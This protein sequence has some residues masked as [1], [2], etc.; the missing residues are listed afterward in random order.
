MCLWSTSLTATRRAPEYLMWPRPI[1]PTPIIPLVSWSLG[2]VYPTPPSTWRGS[3]VAAAVVTSAFFR[4][5]FRSIAYQVN[6]CSNY[7]PWLPG[8]SSSHCEPGKPGKLSCPCY[9][10]TRILLQR[11]FNPEAGLM[12]RPPVVVWQEGAL[13]NSKSLQLSVNQA[14]MTFSRLVQHILSDSPSDDVIIA[15]TLCGKLD[16]ALITEQVDPLIL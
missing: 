15:E 11:R 5:F 8:I 6:C 3:M 12:E 9:S 14:G 13:F 4:N 1:A 2:A 16:T 10:I 7:R